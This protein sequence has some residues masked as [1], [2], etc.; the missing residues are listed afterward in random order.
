MCSW[1]TTLYD[2]KEDKEELQEL[3]D[4]LEVVDDSS[5]CEA[6]GQDD[7]GLEQ[8]RSTLP[9]DLHYSGHELVRLKTADE[10]VVQAVKRVPET[11]VHDLEDYDHN[12]AADNE[13]LP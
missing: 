13:G 9:E 5:K 12:N 11:E 3:L 1:I 8:R 2:G 4:K 7:E 10:M 6:G